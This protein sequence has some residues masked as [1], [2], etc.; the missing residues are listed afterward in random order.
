MSVVAYV[1]AAPNPIPSRQ[2]AFLQ[3]QNLPVAGVNLFGAGV[4]TANPG[5]N[6]SF[7]WFLLKKPA[8]SSAAL[9]STTVQ[10]PIL[11]PVD[12]WGNY[13]LLLVVTNT[14]TGVSSETDPVKAPASAFVQVRVRS[15]NL[16][17]EKPAAGERDWNSVAWRWV[18]KLEEFGAALGSAD[19]LPVFGGDTEGLLPLDGDKALRISGVEGEIS[20]VGEALPNEFSIT[21]GLE[22]PLSLPGSLTV[23]DELNA[24]GDINVAEGQQLFCSVI[25]GGVAPYG[26]LAYDGTT[27]KIN[28]LENAGQASEVL[29]RSDIPS[30]TARAG[31]ILENNNGNN[32]GKILT[33]ERF[34]WNATAEYT[35]RHQ[36]GQNAATRIEGIQAFV[37]A[38]IS[39]HPIVA[40]RNSTGAAVILD[41]LTLYLSSGGTIGNGSEYVFRVAIANTQGNFQENI[42][43]IE[44]TQATIT[45]LAANGTPLVATI[46]KNLSIPNN[47]YLCVLCYANPQHLGQQLSATANVFRNI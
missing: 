44:P 19:G 16:Q 25:K 15:T 6:F 32:T 34:T 43:D 17:L 38:D 41:T 30:T 9:S 28:R 39:S 1:S 37:P 10:N 4:D 7:S 40:W 24:S 27:W 20:V 14:A 5:A 8:G 12:V 29:V 3:Q 13:R 21:V 46:S 22:S 11:Q 26:S 33:R 47:G 36:A 35:I 31:V 2:D 23:G 45:R 18:E 42:F